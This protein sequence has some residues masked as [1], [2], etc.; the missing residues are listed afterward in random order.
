MEC[1]TKLLW[2]L[3]GLAKF[4]TWC[5]FQS[6][7]AKLF[8]MNFSDHHKGWDF[9][10]IILKEI[11]FKFIKVWKITKNTVP[12]YRDLEQFLTSNSEIK[13]INLV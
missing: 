1:V 12:K 6:D 9:L 4:A 11:A 3:I 10:Y 2:N 7:K 5:D 8:L 13:N